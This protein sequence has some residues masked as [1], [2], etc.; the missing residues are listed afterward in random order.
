MPRF[1]LL[2]IDGLG[3]GAQEDSA[4]Y[5][6][7]NAN[8]LLHV[9]EHSKITLPTFQ[10]LGLGNIIPLRT[11][12][13]NPTPLAS[14]GKMR[15]RSA[16]KDSTTGHWE[17]A[18]IELEQPFPTYP[19]GFPDDVIGHLKQITTKDRLLCNKPRSGSEVIMDFG[20]EHLLTGYPILYTSADSVLQIATH[21]D[22]TPIE[23]LYSWCEQIRNA[24]RIGEHAVGRVIARPFTG[25]SG[26]YFR[27]SDQRHD[28]SLV[29]P[30]PN[31]LTYLQQHGIQ[32]FSIGKVIDLF[33]ETGFD[34][35]TRTQGNDDGLA[36]I[37]DW[38]RNTPT[39]EPAFLFANLIDTDQLY[40]HR[41]DV[42]GYA[43][44]L[45]DIDNALP[46]LLNQLHDNDVLIIT[47]D[48]GNDPTTPGTDHSREF[49]P[50][51]MID[52][53]TKPHNLGTLDGF[54]FVDTKARLHF[55]VT[56]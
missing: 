18:G 34:A 35:Y 41:N 42:D 40:G 9:V 47:G 44:C 21:V 52:N 24:Y 7:S 17:M 8:T 26:G 15:E 49:V 32:T 13:E 39:S 46:N 27:L 28:F 10:K 43:Q 22:V 37:I 20:D 33:A 11:I 5:G 45:V 38:L 4:L 30:K 51:L 53:A 31:L 3:C 2:I 48:H 19:D 23:T 36:R 29:P 12:P 25:E 1:I 16:G 6:D 50:L 55:K 14:Y 56:N 54:R